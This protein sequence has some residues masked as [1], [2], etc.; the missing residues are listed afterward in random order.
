VTLARNEAWVDGQSSSI[1]RGL[2]A[3]PAGIG[4]AVFL[5]ADQPFISP[6]LIRSLVDAH[7][8]EA[9]AIVAPLV[10]SGR[11]GNPVLFDRE[12][13][14][15]LRKLQGDEGGRA[16]FSRHHVH[17]VPWHDERIIQDID[18]AADYQRLLEGE[19]Q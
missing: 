5:L 14:D 12:T 9:A 2:D 13:F 16:L 15:D 11:R 18:N 8:S 4:S 6:A 1:K 19:D 7:T 3:C 10:G 17:Y